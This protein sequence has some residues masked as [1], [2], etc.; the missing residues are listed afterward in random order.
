MAGESSRAFCE[1]TGVGEVTR[2]FG[3][4]RRPA[5]SGT[6]EPCDGDLVL[7]PFLASARLF[8]GTSC[9]LKASDVC[10]AAGEAC[11]LRMRS[12]LPIAGDS[13][14]GSLRFRSVSENCSE[15]WR[16]FSWKAMWGLSRRSVDAD[17]G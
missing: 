6:G 3:L 12:L 15:G 9:S 10:G 1:S 13:L 17:R 14:A 8:F 7:E 16:P 5:M 2:S 11:W 4:M